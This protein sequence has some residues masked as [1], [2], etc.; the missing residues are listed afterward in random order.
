MKL[1]VYNLQNK[2]VGEVDVSEDIFDA[3]LKDY[4]HYDVVRAQ[5][6]ARRS[7]TATAK[8]RAQVKGSTQKMYRQ[9]GTGR[10]RHSTT[11]APQFVGGG[12]AFPPQVRDYSLAIPKKAR[13]GALRSAISQKVRDGQLKII[14]DFA[15]D[16]PQTQATLNVLHGLETKKA[17]VVDQAGNENLKLSVRNLK[18]YKFLAA[19]GLN[20]FDVLKFDEVLLTRSA[21]DQIQGALAL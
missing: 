15:V 7:G 20:V 19:E 1:D 18:D 21:V 8:T 13:K 4:L 11:K 9:K 5:L 17:L 10:A 12:R 14:E 3:P 2:K 6:A 16:A